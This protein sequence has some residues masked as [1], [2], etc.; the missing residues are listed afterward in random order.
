MGTFLKVVGIIV[1]VFGVIFIV[2][3]VIG[4]GSFLG[5]LTS[6]YPLP[7]PG[8]ENFP[9]MPTP[10]MMGGLAWMGGIGGIVAGFGII[11]LGVALFCIGAIY[12]DVR[13]L[14]GR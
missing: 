14:R 6:S 7:S 5:M 8:E 12:N 1:L 3:S 2:L 9:P 10:P 4:M 11:V 13:V